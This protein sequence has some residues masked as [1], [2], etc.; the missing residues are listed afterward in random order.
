VQRLVEE[1][2]L[3]SLRE[4]VQL[5]ATNA[6]AL[7]GLALQVLAQDAAPSSRQFGEAD[8]YSRRAEQLFPNDPE[9]Q[10]VRFEVQERIDNAPKP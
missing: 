6:R 2:T 4:A 5:S 7:A 1:N 9:T 8:W 3:D 10:C